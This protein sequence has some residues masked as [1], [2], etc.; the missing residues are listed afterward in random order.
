MERKR[1]EKYHT[2]NV[3]LIGS[4]MP[5]ILNIIRISDECCVNVNK[6]L[7]NKNNNVINAIRCQWTT[8]LIKC[9]ILFVDVGNHGIHIVIVFLK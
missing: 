3:S 2:N 9:D 8:K 6:Q 1:L 4:K 7:L 5:L